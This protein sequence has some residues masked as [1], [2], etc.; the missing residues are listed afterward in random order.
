MNRYLIYVDQKGKDSFKNEGELKG[1]IES[2]FGQNR[3][4]Q[5]WRTYE[6]DAETPED[7]KQQ[8]LDSGEITDKDTLRPEIHDI[9]EIHNKRLKQEAE[10]AEQQ[11]AQD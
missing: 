6:I 4:G 3:E 11:E 10:E 1:Y 9:T 5:L 8:L 2:R 7:A